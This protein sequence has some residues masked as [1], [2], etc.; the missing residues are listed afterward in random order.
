M[1]WQTANRNLGY[2]FLMFDRS[3]V[4]GPMQAYLN[5]QVTPLFNHFKT[6]TADWTKIPEKNTDQY[7]QVNAI[8]IACSTGVTGCEE[9]TTGWFKDWMNTPENNTIHTNL[10]Q[11][12]YCSAIAAGGV[13]EW[14]PLPLKLA[15]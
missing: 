6:I 3:D 12:V 15:S 9:L 10:R 1:P 11:T 2:F 4:Y 5:K 8:S 14:V 13:E 7:N